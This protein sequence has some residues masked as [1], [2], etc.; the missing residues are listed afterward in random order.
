MI[1]RQQSDLLGA[2]C[3]VL[4]K[5]WLKAA[6]SFVLVVAGT[7]GVLQ[8]SPPVF[9]TTARLLIKERVDRLSL[10][11]TLASE[12]AIF[13]TKETVLNTEA[14]IMRTP[15][16]QELVIAAVGEDV[17]EM[18]PA[19]PSTR[20]LARVKVKL[21]E[22]AGDISRGVSRFL[23]RTGI[24]HP[25][26]P[27]EAAV[28]KVRGRLR[29]NPVRNTDVI[30][31][32]LQSRNP[33][34]AARVVNA[35]LDAYLAR[36]NEMRQ[37]PGALSFFTEEAARAR[38]RLE[39][40]EAAL[41]EFRSREGIVQMQEQQ[42]QL[43]R[44]FGETS[45]SIVKTRSELAELKALALNQRHAMEKL[46]PQ[47]V[48]SS[49][50]QRNPGLDVMHVH[51]ANR[52]LERENLLVR[53]AP[54]APLVQDA[55]REIRKIQSLLAETN[56]LLDSTV[57]IGQN[58]TYDKLQQDNLASETQLGAL[59]ARQAEESETLTNLQARLDR[60]VALEPELNRLSRQFGADQAVYDAANRAAEERRMSGAMDRDHIG[61]VRIIDP[62]TAPTEPIRPRKILAMGMSIP[63]GLF[64]AL[65]V[66]LIA[67]WADH[68]FWRE[69]DLACA[70][71]ADM[72]GSLPRD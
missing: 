72:L 40:D 1:P 29:I 13:R 68:T 62:A 19:P 36:Q 50:R 56:K 63:L 41:Q 14:A 15:R 32:S 52:E 64:L 44:Q 70:F 42:Q 23:D 2:I 10:G 57:T 17:F 11:A 49:T 34:A 31:V 4:K 5:H 48:T 20:F 53:Y 16:L 24:T 39:A 43:L 67:E 12:E 54:E 21:S 37:P 35:L 66:T 6:A 69:T 7:Y 65:V 28:A 46:E 59:L 27:F 58:E 9:E 61:N 71:D 25:L 30:E 22:V 45:A 18:P 51:L 8:V 26:T 33:V 55:E 47:V 60:L 3:F 38:I